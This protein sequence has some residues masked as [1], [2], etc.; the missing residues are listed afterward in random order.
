[1]MRR[2]GVRLVRTVLGAIDSFSDD[3]STDSAGAL[4]QDEKAVSV[5]LGRTGRTHYRLDMTLAQA[6]G[7][8]HRLRQAI[9]QQ[10]RADREKDGGGVKSDSKDFDPIQSLLN[11]GLCNDRWAGAWERARNLDYGGHRHRLG[12]GSLHERAGIG[13]VKG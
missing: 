3:L 1:M 6:R 10:E 11:G 2:S 7:L 4:P 5:Y 8:A 9:A 13:A 12:G